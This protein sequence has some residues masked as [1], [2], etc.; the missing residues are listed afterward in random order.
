M[1]RILRTSD[2]VRA[3][4]ETLAGK[5]TKEE[6]GRWALEMNA[7]HDSRWVRFEHRDLPEISDAILKL[8]FLTEGPEWEL[9][10]SE[11]QA[12]MEKLEKLT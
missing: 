3:I 8:I 2:V 10:D 1:E 6:L 5:R 7:K 4:Q 12:M 9:E 11:L